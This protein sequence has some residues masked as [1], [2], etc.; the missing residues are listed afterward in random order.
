MNITTAAQRME[1]MH[2][3][4][5]IIGAQRGREAQAAAFV[6]RRRVLLTKGADLEAAVE[7]AVAELERLKSTRRAEREHGLATA[8]ELRELLDALPQA[9][10]AKIRRLLDTHAGLPRGEATAKT[11]GQLTGK[12]CGHVWW[13]YC[14]FGRKIASALQAGIPKGVE[15][16]M[17]EVRPVLAFAELARPTPSDDWLVRL[18]PQIVEALE[19]GSPR[20]RLSA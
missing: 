16:E 17:F 14:R 8:D 13:E 3:L 2:G 5:R 19:A 4:Y 20:L 1:R 10:E 18:R 6:G 9:W 15:A 12:D 11:L 7:A